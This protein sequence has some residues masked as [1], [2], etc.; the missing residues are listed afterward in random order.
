MIL[1]PTTLAHTLQLLRGLPGVQTAALAQPCALAIGNFDGVHLGHQ[2]I[3]KA[4]VE[5]ARERRLVP[6]VLAFAPHP[7][8]WF[9]SR[10]GHPDDIPAPLSSLRDRLTLLAQQGVEQVILARF[11]EGLAS[12]APEAFVQQGLRAGCQTRWLMVGQ[13]FRYGARRAG[14]IATLHEQCKASGIELHV[15]GDV[16]DQGE[17]V[18]SSGIRHML[19]LG[20]ID[21]ARQAL[22]RW[23]GL[24]GRVIHGAKLGR[25]IGMPTLNLRVPPGPA[26][27]SGILVVRVHGLADRPLP[28]VASLGRRPT[29]ETDGR[30]LLEVH[31]LDWRGD[32][33]GKLV[34]VDY[35]HKLRDERRFDGLEAMMQAMAD[36][37]SQARAWLASHPTLL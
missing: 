4:L 8:A 14:D 17:R 15:M 5:S 34:R 16:I 10:R 33:Y 35:L 3:L 30:L 13:D 23:P 7:R 1:R 37:E 20:R 21:E 19:A 31:V 32:A 12:L 9:A 29:V 6:T 27:P 18:S 25:T 2:A 28:G 22:G 24:T 11:N 36:D 26:V